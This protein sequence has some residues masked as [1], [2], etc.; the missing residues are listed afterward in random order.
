MKSPLQKLRN[1]CDHLFQEIGR[2]KFPKSL[3]SSSATQV[4]HHY[5][6]KSVS[7]ALRYDWDNAIP[8]TTQEHARIHLSE[9]PTIENVILFEKGGEKWFNQLSAK[10]RQYHKVNKAMYE[11]EL[12]RL[13]TELKVWQDPSTIQN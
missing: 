1:E 3:I 11:R 6:P 5:I 8:L 2:L 4:I 9:D 13:Q 10:G 7:S 12:L